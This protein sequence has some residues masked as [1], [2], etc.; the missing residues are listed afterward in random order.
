[1][2]PKMSVIMRFQCTLDQSCDCILFF[3]SQEDTNVIFG[4]RRGRSRIWLDERR[5]G[6]LGR[7]CERMNDTEE[8]LWYDSRVERPTVADEETSD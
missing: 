6:E 3:M 5:A 2:D 1:M 4:A 8:E 7:S